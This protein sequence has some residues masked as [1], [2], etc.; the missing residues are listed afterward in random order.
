[1]MTGSQPEFSRPAPVPPAGAPLAPRPAAPRVGSGGCSAAERGDAS[2]VLGAA[3]TKP[4]RWEVVPEPN[5]DCAHV[6]AVGEADTREEA[7]GALR[8]A[9]STFAAGHGFLYEMTGP[10]EV[11]ELAR[12]PIR[13]P[14]PKPPVWAAR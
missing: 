3:F 4:Y 12:V 8:R 9:L 11:R 7:D 1:M 13:P 10:A 2:P 6:G 14:D 5:P